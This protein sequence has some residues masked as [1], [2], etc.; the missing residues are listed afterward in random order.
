MS[1]VLLFVCLSF[2]YS[3]GVVNLFSISFPIVANRNHI[4]CFTNGTHLTR[5]STEFELASSRNGEPAIISNYC[6]ISN[7]SRL[8]FH[9]LC[10]VYYILFGLFFI[11]C[12]RVVSVFR[13][14]YECPLGIFRICFT[15]WW[16][17]RDRL[18]VKKLHTY[19]KKMLETL[20]FKLRFVKC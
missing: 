15:H 2:F 20:S 18:N 13:L 3:H 1:C 12:N 16:R 5:T 9:M 8:Y 10:L 17:F 6:L 14:Y 19:I 4:L 7:Y 11:S